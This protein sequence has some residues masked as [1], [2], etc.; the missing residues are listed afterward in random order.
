MSWEEFDRLEKIA[1]CIRMNFLRYRSYKKIY[2]ALKTVEKNK[3]NNA[4][5][6]SMLLFIEETSECYFS[7]I[8]LT[9]RL[10]VDYNSKTFIHE[11]Y[12]LFLDKW[13]QHKTSLSE[14]ICSEWLH[15]QYKKIENIRN[16]RLAHFQYEIDYHRDL[17]WLDM[18]ECDKIINIIQKHY[19]NILK[20]LAPWKQ[21]FLSDDIV[22][23]KDK[24]TQILQYI[25]SM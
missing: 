21:F 1:Y 17:R 13:K 6:D 2:N 10:L 12:G 18:D 5:N 25:N 14:T 7:K 3:K 15:D 22:D 4:I 24:L 8:I 23:R 9:L 20:E 11:L 19:T 16:Y